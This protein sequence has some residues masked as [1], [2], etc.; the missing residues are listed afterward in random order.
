MPNADPRAEYWKQAP[1]T[2]WGQARAIKFL[3]IWGPR[4]ALFLAGLTVVALVSQ[5]VR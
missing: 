3:V 1:R 5:T 2:T 4:A